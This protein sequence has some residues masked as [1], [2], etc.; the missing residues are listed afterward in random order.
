M[1]TQVVVAAQAASLSAQ[2]LE[3]LAKRWLRK[4][5]LKLKK[6]YE[7]RSS[8]GLIPRTHRRTHIRPVPDLGR[9]RKSMAEVAPEPLCH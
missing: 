2:A 4:S 7:P 8:A 1:T 5:V 9:H 6:L 3:R